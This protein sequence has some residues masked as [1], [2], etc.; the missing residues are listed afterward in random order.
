L[1]RLPDGALLAQ[2]LNLTTGAFEPAP[3]DVVDEVLAPDGEDVVELSPADF[4]LAT[5]AARARHPR[6]DGPQAGRATP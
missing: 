2:R 6:G 1:D 4:V 3:L 5:D